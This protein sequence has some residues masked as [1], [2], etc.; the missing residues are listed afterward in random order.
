MRSRDPEIVEIA[1]RERKHRDN[2]RYRDPEKDRQDDHQKE[3]RLRAERE[4]ESTEDVRRHPAAHGGKEKRIRKKWNTSI[5][6][7]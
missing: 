4:K 7:H 6:E 1:G 5:P 2:R 3:S